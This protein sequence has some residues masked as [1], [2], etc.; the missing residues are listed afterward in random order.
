MLNVESHRTPEE[1]LGI[2]YLQAAL[3]T[4]GI[5]SDYVD[6]WLEGISSY[7]FIKDYDFSDVL[8]IG[9]SGCLSNVSEVQEFIKLLSKPIPVVVGGYGGTFEYR[10]LLKCGCDV[11][12]IGEGDKA[13][14]DLYNYYMGNCTKESVHNIVFIENSK[15]IHTKSYPV[16]NLNNLNNIHKR[17]YLKYILNSNATVNVISSK[18]CYG[19]CSFC[20]ITQ[21][22]CLYKWREMSIENI[23]KVLE[24]LYIDGARVFKFVDDSFLEANRNDEWCLK[25]SEAIKNSKILKDILFRISIRSDQVNNRRIELLASSGLFAVSCGI[26]SGSPSFLKRVGKRASF[27]DNEHALS[28]FKNNKILVQAGF[29]LFDDRTSINELKENLRFL[30]KHDEI[31]IKGIFSETYAAEGTVFGKYIKRKYGNFTYKKNGN[32]QYPIIDT[33]AR[34]VYKILKN[35]QIKN[36]WLYDKLIDPISAPKALK[37]INEYYKFYDLYKIVHNLDLN[38]FELVLEEYNKVTDI[39]K[40]VDTFLNQSRVFQE[41]INY[42]LNKLYKNNNLNFTGKLSKFL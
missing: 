36:S 26:E 19:S 10:E 27:E 28:V 40:F 38:F 25:F 42:N 39:D 20:S 16:V 15:V 33:D 1:N 32:Y 24:N 41:D 5:E 7:D 11:V 34:K 37:S 21:F 3:A 22:Y 6:L 18:G 23:I 29:M 4:E 9:I 31:I 13:I 30:K 17:K 8:F 12:M 35:Y 2:Y 14:I